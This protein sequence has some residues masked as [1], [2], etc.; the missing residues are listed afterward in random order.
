MSEENHLTGSS[1]LLFNANITIMTMTTPAPA[2]PIIGR[3]CSNPDDVV[4][5]VGPVVVVSVVVV[6]N[7]V[8]GERSVPTIIVSI[9]ASPFVFTMNLSH[10]LMTPL[11]SSS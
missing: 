8:I 1:H 9:D 4:V 10:E 11:N 6:S 7:G 2:I 3:Y 5:P